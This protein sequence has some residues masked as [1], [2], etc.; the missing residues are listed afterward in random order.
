MMPGTGARGDAWLISHATSD[1]DSHYL[2]NYP[3][4]IYWNLLLQRIGKLEMLFMDF[5]PLFFL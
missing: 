5:N 1:C 3:F 2:L 4:V